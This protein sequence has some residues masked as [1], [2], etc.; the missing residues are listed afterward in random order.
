[1]VIAPVSKLIGYEE[2]WSSP[3]PERANRRKIYSIGLFSISA[4][5]NVM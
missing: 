2:L 4:P 1:M 3:G 5:I